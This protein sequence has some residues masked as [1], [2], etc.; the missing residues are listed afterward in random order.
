[1]IDLSLTH[2]NRSSIYKD[3]M[4]LICEIITWM[5]RRLRD[6][7]NPIEE[8]NGHLVLFDREK[9]R[10]STLIMCEGKT[11]KFILDVLQQPP[12]AYE[13]RY[14]ACVLSKEPDPV[15]LHTKDGEE[16]EEAEKKESMP[17]AT[18]ATET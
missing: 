5:M 11:Q 15:V 6:M 13:G 12:P 4:L 1:M 8:Y 7:P 10:W 16:G 17:A 2:D 18:A 14:V 3:D 9:Q